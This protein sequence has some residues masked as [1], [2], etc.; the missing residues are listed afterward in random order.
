MLIMATTMRPVKNNDER[1][2]VSS[3]RNV[4]SDVKEGL[5]LRRTRSQMN[6]RR[7][8]ECGELV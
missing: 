8:W 1:D 5:A 6:V 3:I 2:N 4:E 7:S